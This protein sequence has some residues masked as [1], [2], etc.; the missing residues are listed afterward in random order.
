MKKNILILAAFFLF[1]FANNGFSQ[2]YAPA[3]YVPNGTTGISS[4]NGTTYQ[5]KY[6][7]NTAP[8]RLLD[9][10]YQNPTTSLIPSDLGRLPS[11]RLTY[12]YMPKGITNY[13]YFVWDMVN[14]GTGLFFNYGTI[15]NSLPTIT[16][17]SPFFSFL[18]NG[19]FGIGT[20][21]P[22]SNFR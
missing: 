11:I 6:G 7:F 17:T 4:I 21:V 10:L 3:L 9:L 22:L 12:G 5:G 14:D 15:F 18:N 20:I 16:T 13:K 19:S 2:S 8:V 1:L